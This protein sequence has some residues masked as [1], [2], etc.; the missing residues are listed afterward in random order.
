MSVMRAVEFGAARP[1]PA[2]E[3]DARVRP[4]GVAGVSCCSNCS[5]SAP[6]KYL[7]AAAW[8]GLDRTQSVVKSRKKSDTV[9]GRSCADTPSTAATATTIASVLMTTPYLEYITAIVNHS[10]LGPVL[11]SYRQTREIC[12][13][14]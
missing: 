14:N 13:A 12:D 9:G 11:E 8:L 2:R 4:L 6:E 7:V 3:H 10:T 5:C 1:G